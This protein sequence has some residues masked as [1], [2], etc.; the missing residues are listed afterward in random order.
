MSHPATAPEWLS[1]ASHEDF[2]VAMRTFTDGMG[3]EEYL[4]CIVTDFRFFLWELWKDRGLHRVAPLDRGEFDIAQ[5][6][7]NGPK[8]RGVLA[9]RGVG[10]T[11]F[12]TAA[13]TCFRLR[14]DIDRRILIPS[15]SEAAMKETVAI[16]KGWLN[17]VWFLQ[18]LNPNEGRSL[19][20][21]GLPCR[22]TTLYFD[23]AG[24]K[25]NKQPSVKCIGNEGQL[26]GNRA[27][28]IFP[29]DVETKQNTKTLESRT[30]LKRI[31]KEYTNILY[32]DLPDQEDPDN[33]LLRPIDPTEVCFYGTVKHE[34]TAYASLDA[35]RDKNGNKTYSFRT[36]TLAYPTPEEAR[37]CLG[38]A[39]MIES[40]ML[41][42]RARAGDPV[43]PKRFGHDNIAEKQAEGYQEYQMEHMLQVTLAQSN[44]YPLRLSDLIVM[45]VPRD[46]APATVVYGTR[47][48]AGSTA[49]QDITVLSL[50]ASDALYRPVY[51]SKPEDWHR[52]HGSK[53]F[54]DPAGRG[55][56]ETGVSAVAA[57]GSLLFVKGC[58]GFPG[59]VDEESITK[60]V[61]WFKERDVTD[62]H[63]EGNIDVF[64]T[65]IQTFESI[66]RQHFEEPSPARPSGWK[67]SVTEHRSSGQKE[68]RIIDTLEPVTSTH[69]LVVDRAAITPVVGEEPHQAL[70]YQLSRITKERNCLKLNDRLDSLANCVFLWQHVLRNDAPTSNARLS[71]DAQIDAANEK[72]RK[73]M[74]IDDPESFSFLSPR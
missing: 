58:T 47:D 55:T 29:D 4:A 13:L 51:M 34:E 68:V 16:V 53:G 39:P 25:E 60:I 42:G 9:P 41:T 74:D 72:L 64:G 7:Q 71:E 48:S 50:N 52:Y 31:I 59:G 73:L 57:L 61:L 12:G 8:K 18:D 36:W 15:K 38:L 30:E 65:Y 46:V 17:S 70:Q 22:D 69:R 11:N 1:Q 2:L 20:A 49:I 14:R 37:G 19:R 44:R 10:K 3:Q 63:I 66:V 35:M 26:E 56:D 45:D 21:D 62:I 43:F 23:V 40:D 6:S 33:E 5:F 28:S 27:H 54:V 24:C 32:P 67:A